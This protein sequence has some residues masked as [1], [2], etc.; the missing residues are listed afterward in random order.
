[1][2]DP[3][4]EAEA[5]TALPSAFDV[6]LHVQLREEKGEG[7]ASRISTVVLP[8][9]CRRPSGRGRGATPA[10]FARMAEMRAAIDDA[11][12][13]QHEA[14][15]VEGLYA[16]VAPL[17]VLV[18]GQQGMCL[19]DDC[20]DL[21]SDEMLQGASG[22]SMSLYAVPRGLLQPRVS[23]RLRSLKLDCTR[24]QTLPSW[25]SGLAGLQELHLMGCQISSMAFL[26]ET[27]DALRRLT[28][29]G[30]PE[31]HELLSSTARLSTLA[32][33]S[34]EGC[35]DLRTLPDLRTAAYTALSISRCKQLA[36]VTGVGGM[37]LLLELTL[38]GLHSLVVLPSFAGLASLRT[39]HVEACHWLSAPPLELGA[40]TSLQ[41]LR[42]VMCERMAHNWAPLG[43][44]TGLTELVMRNCGLRETPR[45]IAALTRLRTLTLSILPHPDR[46]S[47]QGMVQVLPRLQALEALSLT[48]AVVQMQKVLPVNDDDAWYVAT[49]LASAPPPRLTLEEGCGFRLW[50]DL[51]AHPHAAQTRFAHE[52]NNAV[53]QFWGAQIV[54]RDKVL[55][56]V[57]FCAV[58]SGPSHIFSE[59]PCVLCK[60][61]GDLVLSRAM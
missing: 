47:Y 19:A 42:V 30:F 46:P 32:A 33:L 56:F 34:V 24:L 45:S 8:L 16:A 54:Q 37:R 28:L 22:E 1:M 23:E 53:L 2:Q 60:P 61:V 13:Q 18:G 9:A 5:W 52:D 6:L 20:V 48:R 21:A 41:A 17:L 38:A 35:E 51:S 10:E 12:E 59:F 40:V 11:L 58:T 7:D 26:P 44:L 27:L 3:Q 49:A 50:M 4:T 39:F 25:M 57:L 55:L 15:D 43:A 29:R 36:L 14:L 31:I